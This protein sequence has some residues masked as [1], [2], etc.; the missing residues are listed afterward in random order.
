MIGYE[1]LSLGFLQSFTV[2]IRGT[3]FVRHFGCCLQE[4]EWE[5]H[6]AQNLKE[7]EQGI[8]MMF[9]GSSCWDDGDGAG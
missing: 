8:S 3:N 5:V 6:K 9:L 4:P 7:S 2:I 1:I